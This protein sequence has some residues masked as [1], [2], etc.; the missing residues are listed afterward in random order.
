VL[1]DPEALVECLRDVVLGLAEDE[2]SSLCK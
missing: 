2:P 1:F